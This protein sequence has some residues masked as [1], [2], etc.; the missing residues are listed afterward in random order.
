M[1]ALSVQA[2]EQDLVF[3]LN[4]IVSDGQH[5]RVFPSMIALNTRTNTA[6]TVSTEALTRSSSRTESILQYLPLLGTKGALLLL[7]GAMRY[8]DNLTTDLW[9]TMV[10]G[11]STH[12]R[13]S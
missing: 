8:N 7:G 12:L 9:G 6:R 2:P 13:Q 5:G 10:K 1:N 11:E 4:G 3:A